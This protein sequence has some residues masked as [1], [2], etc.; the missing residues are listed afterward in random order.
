MAHEIEVELQKCE[1]TLWVMQ[2]QYPKLIR[3]AANARYVYDQKW[4]E[5]IDTITHRA[6]AEGQKAPTVAQADAEATMMV[7]SEMKAT[8]DAEA[9][10]NIAKMHISTLEAILSSVQT[11]SKL[12]L[13]EMALTR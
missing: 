6:L 8:R 9:E 13:A 2:E 5:S 1:S 12:L 3:D 11:R 10:V 4:A 7:K